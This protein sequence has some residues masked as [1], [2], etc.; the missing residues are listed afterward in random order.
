LSR[1]ELAGT[2]DQVVLSALLPAGFRIYRP[3]SWLRQKLGGAPLRWR[4]VALGETG[5]AIAETPWRTVNWS[6][7]HDQK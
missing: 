4:V 3:P 6:P 1:V 2:R 5:Q 7:E